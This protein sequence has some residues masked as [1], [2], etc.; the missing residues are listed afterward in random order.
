LVS[1]LDVLNEYQRSRR[2][3]VF[4]SLVTTSKLFEKAEASW[5]IGVP[6]AKKLKEG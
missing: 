2:A 3:R 4:G 5:K 6:F 1:A